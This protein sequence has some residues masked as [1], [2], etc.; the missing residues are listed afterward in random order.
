MKVPHIVPVDKMGPYR[1]G[2]LNNVSVDD[3]EKVLGFKP[4]CKDD[5]NKVEYSWGFEVDGEYAAIWDYYGS[6]RLN[7]WSTYDPYGVLT[8]LFKGAN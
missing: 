1:I 6:H 3:I 7:S 2:T 5:P 4:N 8:Q